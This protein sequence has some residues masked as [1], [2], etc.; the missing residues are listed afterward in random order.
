MAVRDLFWNCIYIARNNYM[1]LIFILGNFGGC[2][3][4]LWVSKIP[5]SHLFPSPV[6]CHSQCPSWGSE[7]VHI[8]YH[9][10]PLKGQVPRGPSWAGR[11]A[12]VVQAAR[13]TL[14]LTA[15]HLSLCCFLLSTSV[16]S[17]ISSTHCRPSKRSFSAKATGKGQSID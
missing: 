16:S 10:N 9:S 15:R 11:P 7:H 2:W 14:A 6:S 13:E 8:G 3:W 4:E 5:Q 17:N 12:E 1:D